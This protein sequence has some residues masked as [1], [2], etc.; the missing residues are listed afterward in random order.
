MSTA[1]AS[2]A[3][4]CLLLEGSY[5]Y[6]VGG[7]SNWADE[8]MRSH[9]HLTYHLVA[10]LPD[11]NVPRLRYDLPPNAV[12]LDH[13]FLQDV[14]KGPARFAG[15]EALLT[16]IEPA[17]GRLQAA[18]GLADLAAV[19][20]AL[21]PHRGRLGRRT[22]LDSPEAWQLIVRMYEST[23]RGTS[24]LDYFWTWRAQI[25]GLFAALLCDLPPAKVYHTTSTGYAGLL[26]ARAAL[27]TG[28]PAI[29]TEHGI[30]TDERRIEI[31]MAQW[32]GRQQ[33]YGFGVES[34]GRSLKDLWVDTFVS[35]SHAC[36]EACDAIVTLY[37]GNQELQRRDGAD[38][39]KM[40]V[41]P[42]G[43]DYAGLSRIARDP[44]PRRPTVAFI[45]RV[46][47]I[48]DVKTFIYSIA[49]LRTMVPDIRALVLGPEDEDPE[50]AAEC[51][52][53]VAQADLAKV[54]SFAGQVRLE[55]YLDRIDVV[56]LTSISEAQPLVILEAGAAGVP[57]VA[58]DVGA[59]REMIQGAADEVPAFGP[60]GA[61]TALADPVATAMAVAD[62]LL[63]PSHREA[64][65]KAIKARVAATYNRDT[66]NEVYRAL[67]DE[68][69]QR[70]DRAAR[71]AEVA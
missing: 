38:P 66:L 23:V 54:V 67:Y 53:L 50:Y 47:P 43:V 3:D 21:A 30:Y 68:L 9:P 61:I 49:H 57:T 39:A 25:G 69:R 62:L 17:L 2:P 70:P 18:G 12:G 71:L 10:L 1:A 26:A 56:V 44:T 41:I 24:F 29:V 13:V 16:R 63:R 59:C 55:D 28:R 64:C 27:E 34:E 51:R 32:L 8:L 4:V 19:I 22:L 37:Q 65:A 7:V 40:L 5:P 42:N 31:A 11:R 15:L 60:G 48:K 33:R 52:K 6:V 58:T 36:Y 45:G 35:Y 46:V 20:D 14:G